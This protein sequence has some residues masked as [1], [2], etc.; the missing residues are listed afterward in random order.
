MRE[1]TLQRIELLGSSFIPQHSDARV[2]EQLIYKWRHSRR[3]IAD[4]LYDSYIALQDDGWPL[5]PEHIRR[6]V[7]RMFGGVYTS[8]RAGGK[9][10][11]QHV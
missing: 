9:N 2:L 6:D 7:R 1:I 3:I 10:D 8:D 5:T 11:A 4:A